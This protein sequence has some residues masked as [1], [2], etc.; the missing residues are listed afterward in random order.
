[1]AYNIQAPSI[2]FS[3]L[4]FNIFFFLCHYEK[5]TEALTI[6]RQTHWPPPQTEPTEWEQAKNESYFTL[7]DRYVLYRFESTAEPLCS[8]L[9]ALAFIWML[10]GRNYNKWVCERS[11][12][13]DKCNTSRNEY[14]H[15]PIIITYVTSKEQLGLSIAERF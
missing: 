9:F 1:M 10:L 3:T 7:W 2:S 8:L 5:R 13:M 6:V 11:G 12:Y 15:K 14:Q 4:F